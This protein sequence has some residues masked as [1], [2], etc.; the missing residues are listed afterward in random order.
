MC[1]PAMSV[2]VKVGN[3][4]TDDMNDHV[5]VMIGDC[6][7]RKPLTPE[8]EGSRVWSLCALRC[9]YIA[10]RTEE[11]AEKRRIEHERKKY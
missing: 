3:S 9:E 4:S 10:D 7:R 5:N 2:Q 6:Q 1:Y 8:G 11:E